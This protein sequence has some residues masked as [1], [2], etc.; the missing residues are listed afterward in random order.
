MQKKGKYLKV[1]GVKRY[2]FGECCLYHQK[3]VVLH[4]YTNIF[5]DE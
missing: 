1:S 3:I 2:F 4:R 5:K